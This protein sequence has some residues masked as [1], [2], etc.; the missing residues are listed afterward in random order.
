MKIFNVFKRK[1][2]GCTKHKTTEQREDFYRSLR[3]FASTNVEFY[4]EQFDDL[5]KKEKREFGKFLRKEA[6]LLD[7]LKD[8]RNR[9]KKLANENYRK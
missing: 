7:R 9:L 2:R 1:R 4:N 6:E 5:T 3:R 8:L